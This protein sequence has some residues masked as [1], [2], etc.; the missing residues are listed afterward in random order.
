MTPS[1]HSQNSHH[2]EPWY[3]Q[4]T[5]LLAVGLLL[6]TVTAGFVTLYIAAQGDDALVVSE[7]EYQQIK[8]DLRA[9]ASQDD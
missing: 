2:A 9:V 3:K 5:M 7:K 1:S 4:S 6:A 8:N